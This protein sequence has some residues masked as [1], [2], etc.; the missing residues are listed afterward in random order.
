MRITYLQHLRRPESTSTKPP[1][2][3]WYKDT[4]VPTS[5]QL[6]AAEKFFLSHTPRKLWTATEWRKHPDTGTSSQGL[7]PEVAFLGR[8]NVGKSSLLNALLL[9]PGLN[10]VGP[11]PGKTKEMHAWALSPTNPITGGA[12]RGMKGDMETKCAVLDMPGYGH[13]SHDT[14]GDEILK[15][16]QNRI[17]LKRVFLLVDLLHGMK[18]S[19]LTMLKL[20]R[21]QGI[22]TQVVA[23]KCDKLKQAEGALM[24]QGLWDRIEGEGIRQPGLPPLGEV[25][26]VGNVGDGRKNDTV[27][28]KNM[29]GVDEV[30]WAILRATGLGTYAVNKGSLATEANTSEESEQTKRMQFHPTCTP[31]VRRGLRSGSWRGPIVGYT[32]N[33]LTKSYTLDGKLEPSPDIAYPVRLVPVPDNSYPPKSYSL[34]RAEPFYNPV[35]EPHLK[36]EAPEPEPQVKAPVENQFYSF[37][38][39]TETYSLSSSPAHGPDVKLPVISGFYTFNPLTKTYSKLTVIKREEW[40][41]SNPR[42]AAPGLARPSKSVPTPIPQPKLSLAAIGRGIHDLM[43]VVG[44]DP[45]ADEEMEGK[46]ESETEMEGATTPVPQSPPLPSR[47]RKRTITHTKRRTTLVKGRTVVEYVEGPAEPKEAWTG[48]AVGGMADLEALMERSLGS[49]GRGPKKTKKH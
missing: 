25:L 20:L 22:S 38:S 17:Q 3:S 47:S 7:I 31:P 11:R 16:L 39:R 34:L 18:N 24:V 48:S 9:S 19:D 28:Y 6:Q 27:H 12:I 13:A 26:V 40:T 30:Q 44:P 2:L 5:A 10:Y 8:S 49:A 1:S 29:R 32:Y 46:G 4:A 33:P 37:N 21:K 15:Y 43:A 41:R 45:E 23:S 14:W 42:H 36:A 35:T